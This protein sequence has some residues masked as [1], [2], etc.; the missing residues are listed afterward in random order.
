MVQ[1]L[2]PAAASITPNP[3]TIREARMRELVRQVA[4]VLRATAAASEE[5]R[6]LAP[7]AMAALG[8]AGILRAFLPPAYGGAEL[9]PVY[10][11]RLFEELATV[12][13]AASWVGMIAAAGAWLTILL[14]P[15]AADEIIA[16]PRAVV[17][18]SLF[19]PLTAE[20]VPG[21]YRV[22]GRTAFGSGCAYTTWFGAQAI[23]LDNGAPRLGPGGIPAMPASSST[24]APWACAAPAATTSR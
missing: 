19:P 9:G 17:N 6:Q 15:R 12:D 10:G 7:E 4:P 13:S 23:V 2:S 16:D 5:A 14:P 24:G 22:S 21:G 11:I 1:A 3:T 18:G 20:P 8:E